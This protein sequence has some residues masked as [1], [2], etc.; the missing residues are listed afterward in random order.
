MGVLLGNLQ[1]EFALA[2]AIELLVDYVV[3]LQHTHHTPKTKAVSHM[4]HLCAASASSANACRLEPTC[5][6]TS[7]QSAPLVDRYS[8]STGLAGS[9]WV[10][11]PG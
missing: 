10:G 5:V 2:G 1:F 4:L 11:N 7:G 9:S 6:M 8:D 3:H